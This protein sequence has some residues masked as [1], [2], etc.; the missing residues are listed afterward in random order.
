MGLILTV[1]MSLFLI[2][3]TMLTV[4]DMSALEL[5]HTTLLAFTPSIRFSMMQRWSVVVTS[6]GTWEM[7]APTIL[8][9][10]LNIT[11]SLELLTKMNRCKPSLTRG[12]TRHDC[13]I[14]T[15]EIAQS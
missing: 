13:I 9:R 12:K 3:R 8:E 11:E 7:T 2:G 1:S 15:T 4:L 5:T 10:Y 6:R 14:S